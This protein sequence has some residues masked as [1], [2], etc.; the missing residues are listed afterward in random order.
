MP[1]HFWLFLLLVLLA[2]AM[3]GCGKK[4]AAPKSASATRARL[5]LKT[6][7][8]IPSLGDTRTRS[9]D[10]SVMVY[11]PAG[12]FEMGS[13]DKEVDYALQL[14][15]AYGTNCNRRYFSV[16]QP[17]HIVVLDG[18]WIDK[19]EVTNRQYRQCKEAGACG[20]LGCRERVSWEAAISPRCV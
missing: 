7:V 11:V 19:T 1:R 13:D 10:G 17:A 15:G 9:L 14:C 2:L 20:E 18:F 4:E 5:E 3:V 6:A 12:E 16:E 8:P